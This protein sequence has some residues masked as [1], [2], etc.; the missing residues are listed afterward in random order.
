LQQECDIAFN[1]SI[2]NYNQNLRTHFQNRNEPFD[3]QELF[4][5]LKEAREGAIEE[6]GVIGDVREKYPNY[7][8]YLLR[9]QD[10]IN[11]QEEMIITINENLA[12]KYDYQ[13]E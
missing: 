10:I 4:L 11:K 1:Q 2:E 13:K 9:I 5:V 12:E 3:T 7:D 6:F 8:D